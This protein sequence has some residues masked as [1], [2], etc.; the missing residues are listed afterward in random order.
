MAR[1]IVRLVNAGVKV[2]ITTHSDYLVSQINNLLRASYASD[3]WL[4]QHGFAREDC[5]KRDDV[6]AYA[7]GWDEEEGGSRVKELEIRKDVGIDEDEF[8]L[9]ANALYDETILV[10]RIRPK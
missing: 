4:K 2:L 3:R 6:S 10:E 1:A 7:F 5:L 9:V 8:A